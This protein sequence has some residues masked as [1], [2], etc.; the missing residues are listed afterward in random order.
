MSTE[1]MRP[2]R[3]PMPVPIAHAGASEDASRPAPPAPDAATLAGSTT[4]GPHDRVPLA[5]ADSEC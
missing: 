1:L 3:H 4:Y 5:D 2:E